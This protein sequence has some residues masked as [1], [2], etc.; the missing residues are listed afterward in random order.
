MDSKT[1]EV[2]CV[3]LHNRRVLVTRYDDGG[4]GLFFKKLDDNRK[5]VKT[6]LGLSAEAMYAVFNCYL[7][8]VAPGGG[9]VPNPKEADDG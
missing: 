3:K 2:R 1:G 6:S 8:I 9:V 7:D 5:I 4:Y